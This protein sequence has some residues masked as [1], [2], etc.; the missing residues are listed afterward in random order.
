MKSATVPI[1]CGAALVAMSTAATCHWWSVRQFAA[2]VH[3]GL[4]VIS[5][6]PPVGPAVGPALPKAAAPR[7]LAQGPKTLEPAPTTDATQKKFYETLIAKM[8]GLQN[9]NRDLLNQVAET[10]RDMMN[11]NF[12][13]DT[14]SD[15]FRP[16]PVSE[17]RPDTS[18]EDGPGVLPPRAE[19]VFLP[20]DQ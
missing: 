14:F 15:S 11:L 2:A 7:L 13:V 18:S 10:N 3:A 19:P 16:M 9:Q 12:R 4:P 8:E 6:T 1:I 5:R 20:S 17:D